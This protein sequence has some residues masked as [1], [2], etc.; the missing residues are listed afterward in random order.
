MPISFRT[1][2]TY[3]SYSIG[4]S[5]GPVHGTRSNRI[6]LTS[7]ANEPPPPPSPSPRYIRLGEIERKYRERCGGRKGG[8]LLPARLSRKTG[9]I[10][11]SSNSFPLWNS[12]G[13][14]NNRFVSAE[15]RFSTQ[16]SLA[17][18]ER[19]KI[20]TILRRFSFQS[21]EFRNKE[22]RGKIP[23]CRIF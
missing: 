21:E 9:R 18:Q 2:F 5:S 12:R 6:R 16:F 8:G 15:N 10:P 3:R 20:S 7:R 22:I 13:I 4:P 19:M 11:S 1:T 17:S 23:L 14:R